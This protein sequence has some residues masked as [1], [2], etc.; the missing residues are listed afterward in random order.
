MRRVWSDDPESLA[1][2]KNRSIESS[3]VY[4]EF[5]SKSGTDGLLGAAP[6]VLRSR[7]LN[8]GFILQLTCKMA[9]LTVYVAYSILSTVQLT[10]A[11]QNPHPTATE[12]GGVRVSNGHRK[13]LVRILTRKEKSLKT[14][15][16]I[17]CNY[18]II[19]V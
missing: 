13:V 15:H 6:P 17:Y 3:R 19:I 11:R 8:G 2:T 4:R 16:T 14:A 9:K 5:K 1:L 10:F 12:W 7:G 18:S